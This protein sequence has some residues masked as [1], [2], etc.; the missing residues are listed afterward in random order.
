M[1]FNWDHIEDRELFQIDSLKK[2]WL[3]IEG[4][5][6]VFIDEAQKISNIGTILKILV[7]TYGKEKQ[8]VVTGSSSI[9]I[10]DA[11]SE[12]LTGRKVVYNIYPISFTEL[13]W[14]I[15]LYD[16]H[17]K[18]EELLI[19]WWY[20]DIINQKTIDSK[21]LFLKELTNA[22]LYRDILEFQQIRNSDIILRLLKLIALQI[23]SEVSIHELSKKLWVDSK[24]VDRYIDL[25]IKSYI[26]FK[27]PPLFSNKRK[28][29]NKQHKIFFYDLGIRNTIINDF[30]FLDHRTDVWA[31]WE[32]FL[33]VERLKKNSYAQKSI[34]SYFWRNYNKQ[35]VEYIEEA[36]SHIHAYEF[37]WWKKNPKL[38]KWFSE[39]FPDS[40]FEVINTDNYFDFIGS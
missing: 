2:I 11:T 20:P 32:N 13:T 23:W 5:D 10:L 26:I 24:T 30:S 6:I 25:L 34:L 22:N 1:S 16:A 27:L 31:L 4:A 33:I 14:E 17:K 7:D 28:E 37:K 21:K 29:I 8:I 35:E 36:D 15:W 9:N 12:P 38:P 3:F 39:S 19:F 40:I 18:L